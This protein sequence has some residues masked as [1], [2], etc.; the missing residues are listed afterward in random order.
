MNRNR[1][2]YWR[3][4]VLAG[5]LTAALVWVAAANAA[6]TLN[7]PAA[8]A[9]VVE[10]KAVTFRWSGPLQGDPDT[11]ERSYFRVEIADTGSISGGQN[12]AWPLTVNYVITSPG[13]LVQSATMG[14]PDGGSYSWRVCGWGVADQSVDNQLE[15]LSC[16]PKRDITATAKHVSNSGTTDRVTITNTQHVAAPSTPAAPRETQPR[17]IPQRAPVATPLARS[18]EAATWAISGFDPAGLHSAVGNGGTA[19]GTGGGDRSAFTTVGNIGGS[20]LGG[21][22][23]NIPGVPIPFWALLVLLLP[24]PGALL[25]RRSALKM[26]DIPVAA[27]PGV[28]DVQRQLDSEY[29][30][31]DSPLDADWAH[32]PNDTAT[33]APSTDRQAVA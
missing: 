19:V 14:V 2:A 22:A 10:D 5:T 31:K 9:S 26:F 32:T 8:G 21:L 33:E 23:A 15:L 25:W 29:G 4:I 1:A 18:R 30:V 20:I 7:S 16:S 11:L 6:P 12:S 28:T 17:T 13:V 3:A 24:I 27:A